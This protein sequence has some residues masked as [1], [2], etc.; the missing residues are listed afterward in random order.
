MN[1]VTEEGNQYEAAV[2]IK[3]KIC[4][5]VVKNIKVNLFLT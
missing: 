5:T 1:R 3:G 4:S 2:E